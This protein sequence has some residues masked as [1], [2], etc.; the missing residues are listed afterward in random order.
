MVAARFAMRFL[1]FRLGI[2]V[3]DLL[4]DCLVALVEGRIVDGQECKRSWYDPRSADNDG[5]C[6]MNMEAEYSDI[7]VPVSL[8]QRPPSAPEII[9]IIRRHWAFLS[10]E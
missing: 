2:V 1:S 4:L 10:N 6:M 3:D 9:I 7:Q 8:K 5:H